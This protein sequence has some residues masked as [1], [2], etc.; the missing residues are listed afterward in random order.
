[1]LENDITRRKL[2]FL[3]SSYYLLCSA[4]NGAQTDQADRYC[5]YHNMVYNIT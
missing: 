3:E 1:M 4:N 5:I 2:K